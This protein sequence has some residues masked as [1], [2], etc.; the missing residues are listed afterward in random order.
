MWTLV[1]GQLG[2]VGSLLSTLWDPEVDLNSRLRQEALLSA[3]PS[4][5]S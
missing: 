1:R 5:G 3:E 4:L 2:R